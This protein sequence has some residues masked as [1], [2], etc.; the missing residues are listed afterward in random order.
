MKRSGLSGQNMAK[1]EQGGLNKNKLTNQDQS[2]HM[3]QIGP[4]WII[5]DRSGHNG[6]NRI[7]MD[8]IGTNRTE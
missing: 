8:R 5:V 3:D 7:N 4:N 2:G 1:W 6:T